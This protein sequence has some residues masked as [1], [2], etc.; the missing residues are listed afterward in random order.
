MI[1]DIDALSL[2]SNIHTKDLPSLL[3]D[4]YLHVNSG[5][6]RSL[7]LKDLKSSNNTT[8]DKLSKKIYNFMT[9][10]SGFKYLGSIGGKALE[11]KAKFPKDDVIKATCKAFAKYIL[12]EL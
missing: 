6:R 9:G 11:K 8:L 3:N 10:S 1:V 12:N 4:Y 2:A 5:I 7:I